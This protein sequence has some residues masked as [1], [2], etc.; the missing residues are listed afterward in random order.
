MSPDILAMELK[1]GNIPKPLVPNNKATNLVFN[2]PMMMFIICTPP[3][4]P[5]DFM[6]LMYVPCVK[7]IVCKDKQTFHLSQEKRISN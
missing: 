1:M 2:R 7:S 6:F 5:A 4:R 3:K